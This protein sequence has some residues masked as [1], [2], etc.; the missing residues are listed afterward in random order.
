MNIP[1]SVIAGFN[2]EFPVY[3]VVTS[4]FKGVVSGK[5]KGVKNTKKALINFDEIII[6]GD[7]TAIESFPV[8]Y[9]WGL[10]KSL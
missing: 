8:F 9:K 1:Y 7:R 3:G 2:E 4:P 10:K 6:N 5:I